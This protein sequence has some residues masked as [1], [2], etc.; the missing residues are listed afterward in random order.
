MKLKLDQK[1]IKEALANPA[2]M[3]LTLA[4]ILEYEFDPG[5]LYGTH[6][7]DSLDPMTVIRY[8]E[9]RYQQ[10]IPPALENRIQAILV[11]RTTDGFEKN[12]MAFTAITL[13]LYDGYLGDVTTGVF[14]DLDLEE[15]LWG[16]FESACID[17][18][19]G[20]FH[21][22]VGLLILDVASQPEEPQE[23]DQGANVSDV[24]RLMDLVQSQMTQIGVPAEIQDKVMSRGQAALDGVAESVQPV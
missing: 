17:P 22:D 14:E 11:L 6:E 4:F 10:D 2:T 24:L 13:A 16:V 1:A 7:Q 19:L 21:D 12:P 3:G 9:D 15:V 20:Q 23:E 5:E 8:M 18:Q